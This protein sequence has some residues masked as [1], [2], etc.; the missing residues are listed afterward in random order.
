MTT[1][2]PASLIP[3]F[4]ATNQQNMKYLFGPVNSRRLGLSLGIDIMPP[5]VCNYNCIYCEVGATTR[6]T[7]ERREYVDTAAVLAEL[8]HFIQHKEAGR[9]PDVYT[10]TGS[11]EPTLHSSIGRIIRFLKAKTE[12]PVAVLTNASL[13][14]LAEVREALSAADIVVPSLDGARPESFR[15]VNRPARCVNLEAVIAGIQL[16]RREFAGRLWLEILLVK[17]CNDSEV[18]IIALQD[19][20]RTIAPDRIQLHTVARPPL[21]N[22]AEPVNR[23]ALATIAKQL[24]E[25][26]GCLVEVPAAFIGLPEKNTE[27][28]MAHEIIEMLRRRPGT[29]ADV[30]S[31]LGL[32]PESARRLLEQMEKGGQV[33]G[34]DYGGHKYYQVRLHSGVG[35]ND[36]ATATA[37][38]E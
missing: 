11:G 27:P 3:F 24:G 20:I 25:D 14:H 31:A 35:L 26:S 38:K 18:D 32:A 16:F 8:D 21:E 37:I 36:S 17:D 6:L 10:V 7:C 12:K 30:C 19:A 1:I 28:V 23:D 2:G 22:Y 33:H 4:Q 13:L 5:K 9:P 29:A 34:L 15:R